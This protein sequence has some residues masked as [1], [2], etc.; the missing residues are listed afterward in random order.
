MNGHGDTAVATTEIVFAFAAEK[1]RGIAAAV[2]EDDDLFPRFEDPAQLLAKAGGADAHT[3]ILFLTLLMPDVDGFRQW[4]RSR[5]NAA[6]QPQQ[7]VF[8]AS[9]ILATLQRGR[10]RTQHHGDATHLSANHGQ[11]A[12]VVARTL[13]LL[14][15]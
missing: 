9:S 15:R 11:I 13:F 3:A 7:R 4:K 10:C 5:F 12:G 14:V 8:S 6:L 2:D 1:E